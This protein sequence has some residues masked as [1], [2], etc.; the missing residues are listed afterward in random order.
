MP[1]PQ[2]EIQPAVYIVDD[3][4]VIRR[5]MTLVL[6]QEGMANGLFSGKES[7]DRQ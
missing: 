4:A 5:A 3:D 1:N 2:N 7:G 6:E